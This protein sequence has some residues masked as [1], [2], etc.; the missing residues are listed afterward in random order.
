M[1]KKSLIYGRALRLAALVMAIALIFG[2]MAVFY[3]EGEGGT[4][5]VSD[6]DVTS[7]GDTA[8]TSPA[9]VTSPSDTTTTSPSDVTTT[10]PSDA[11]TT[12]PSDVTT[13]SP[14]DVTTTSPSDVTSSSDVTTSATAAPG[15]LAAL[16]CIPMSDT[17][18]P[19]EIE[20]LG[21]GGSM[22]IDI[23]ASIF[24]FDADSRPISSLADAC[25]DG[26]KVDLTGA[27]TRQLSDGARVELWQLEG[28]P[29]FYIYQSCL[30]GGEVGDE[31]KVVLPI[32]VT[33][34]NGDK[35]SAQFDFILRV[36]AASK[37]TNSTSENTTS[38]SEETSSDTDKSTEATSKST[39]KST[40]KTTKGGSGNPNTGDI[41]TDNTDGLNAAGG[42]MLLSGLVILVTLAADRMHRDSVERRNRANAVRR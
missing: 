2:S 6:A 32:T 25:K 20:S 3:A 37:P 39:S 30:A 15:K 12:S 34:K 42:A 36:T 26:A 4:P 22:V 14:S 38:S 35:A 23:G 18:S 41:T 17:V 27:Y 33:D 24:L 7:P 19:A 31:L 16:D 1:N 5:E 11:T 8:V 40:A 21:S 28:E 29:V 10:S 13:T 9:D